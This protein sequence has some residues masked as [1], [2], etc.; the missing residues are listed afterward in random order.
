MF[1][2]YSVYKGGKD[3]LSLNLLDKQA[4]DELVYNVLPFHKVVT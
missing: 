3:V 1:N 2:M 4:K